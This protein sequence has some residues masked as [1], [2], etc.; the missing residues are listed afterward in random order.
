M[1]I[2]LR[3]S[4]AAVV[5][6]GLLG[7]LLSGLLGVGG[8]TVLVPL[9]VLV[10]LSQHKAHATSLAAIVPLAAV[11][12]LTFAL[13]DAIDYRVGLLLATGALAG[14]PLGAKVMAALKEGPLQILF[15]AF[16]AVV[17]LRLLFS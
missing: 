15:G 3:G 1:G 10:G 11:G 16:L 6:I 8:G 7:G 2:G 17:A 13:E 5:G 9:L 4:A 12:A 14:A